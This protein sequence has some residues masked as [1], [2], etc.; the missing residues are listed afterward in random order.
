MLKRVERVE[1][2]ERE[3]A[4]KEREQWRRMSFYTAAVLATEA[5]GIKQVQTCSKHVPNMFQ[6]GSNRYQN[7]FKQEAELT[8][9]RGSDCF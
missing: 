4:E 3:R 9:L 7:R 5:K 6:T 8:Q 2:V 1:R